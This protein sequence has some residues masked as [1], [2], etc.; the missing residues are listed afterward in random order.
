M[1]VYKS[2]EEKN[3][4][5][6]KKVFWLIIMILCLLIAA[7]AGYMFWERTHGGNTDVEKY[8]TNPDE[9][10]Q[11]EVTDTVTGDVPSDTEDPSDTGETPEIP[12]DG[13]VDFAKLQNDNPDIYAWI[14]VPGTKI[15]YPI[16]QSED[17][18]TYYLRRDYL[19]N[20][21]VCGCIFTQYY[22]NKDFSDP[23]TVIYGHY[24]YD[25]TFFGGLHEFRSKQFFD[26]HSEFYIYTPGRKL[27]YEIFSAYEY[28]DRHI[29]LSF[30]FTDEEVFADYLDSC[31]HPLSV[32]RNVRDGITLTTEDKIVTLSTCV[33]SGADNQRYLVQ[34]VLR[35][36][37]PTE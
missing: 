37:E 22:N 4:I 8:K 9:S 36:D 16:V 32:A 31:L 28:D 10:G 3:K 27:T 15:D 30:D 35:S 6:K 29:M 18:L 5:N 24:M 26:E 1:R 11:I 34:G 14:V 7:G 12:T 13:Y 17:N 21:D 25:K 19:G 20:R 23:N 2:M 33:A